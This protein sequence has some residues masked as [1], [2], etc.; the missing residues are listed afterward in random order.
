MFLGS[1][2]LRGLSRYVRRTLFAKNRPGQLEGGVDR[3]KWS[4]ARFIVFEQ[5]RKHARDRAILNASGHPMIELT[6]MRE[7]DD[8]YGARGLE[9]EV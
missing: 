5:P 3:L 9:R 7:L 6:S 4:L 1:E 8:L 2:P